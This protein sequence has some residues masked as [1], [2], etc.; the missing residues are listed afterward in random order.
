MRAVVSVVVLGIV[1]SE[2][3]LTSLFHETRT[4]VIDITLKTGTR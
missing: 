2:K 1:S 4:K 3:Q